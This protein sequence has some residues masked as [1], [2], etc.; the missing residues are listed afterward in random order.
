MT[1]ENAIE[2]YDRTKRDCREDEYPEWVTE[3]DRCIMH[4][5]E[6]DSRFAEWV[7]E[8]LKVVKARTTVSMADSN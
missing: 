5:C 7:P 3:I 2:T 4:D 8:V 1:L 6:V